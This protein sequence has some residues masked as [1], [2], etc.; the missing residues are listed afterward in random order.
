MS[1]GTVRGA[2]AREFVKSFNGICQW[3]SGWER[4]NDMVNLFAI[5]IANT[6]DLNNREARTKDYQRIRDKYTPEEFKRFGNLFKLLVESLERNPFQDFLG[7][8]Y[9]QLDMGSKAHGQCFTP[10]SVCQAMANLAM[11][12]EQVKAKI[13]SNGWISINDCACG[14]G[15]TL[16][17]AAEHLRMMDVNYQQTA[18]FVAGDIDHTVAMMCYIQ[19]S[20]LGCAGR[21]RIGDALMDPETGPLLIGNPGPN[22]WYTP[23]FYSEV[24][25]QRLMGWQMENILRNLLGGPETAPEIPT[26][27]SSTETPEAPDGPKMTENAPKAEQ[28]AQKTYQEAKKPAEIALKAVEKP[29]GR[30]SE[31]QLMFDLTGVM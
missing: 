26:T 27:D 31:G 9:M 7:D 11:P 17:A 24:W 18:L 5:E 12:E 3:N 20:L 4:W 25:G 15:A 23:M 2:D 10:F 22:T 6:V 1:A 14:A 19:L 30:M 8:M 28:S 16:I 29:R 21:V 13:E